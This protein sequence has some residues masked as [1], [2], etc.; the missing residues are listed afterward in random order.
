MLQ[1]E[2]YLFE[3]CTSVWT[4]RSQVVFFFCQSGHDVYVTSHISVY[5]CFWIHY[6]HSLFP[7]ILI[8]LHSTCMEMPSMF[9]LP[10][11]YLQCKDQIRRTHLKL[12][13]VSRMTS[14]QVCKVVSFFF[15]ILAL[16]ERRAASRH[17]HPKS[18][19]CLLPSP[20]LSLSLSPQTGTLCSSVSLEVCKSWAPQPNIF[21][22]DQWEDPSAVLLLLFFSSCMSSLHFPQTEDTN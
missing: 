18:S 21:P 3:T 12:D 19:F 11:E 16:Y 15:V 7:Q 4:I 22:S 1:W 6:F 10:H 17:I 5:S 2:L 20:F 14:T 9:M 13:A 8:A